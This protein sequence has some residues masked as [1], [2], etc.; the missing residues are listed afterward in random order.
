[1]AHR[2]QEWGVFIAAGVH[3]HRTGGAAA[4]CSILF[5]PDGDVLLRAATLPADDRPPVRPPIAP[6][7]LLGGGVALI[8]PTLAVPLERDATIAQFSGLVIVPVAPYA[9]SRKTAQSNLNWIQESYRGDA[10]W[11]VVPPAQ[12]KPAR[13]NGA[14]VTAFVA[15]PAVKRDESRAGFGVIR[16][17]GPHRCIVS[18]EL[19]A[20][21]ARV[22]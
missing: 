22:E 8:E 6:G 20:N 3:E 17:A 19:P 11:L 16:A 13:S 14:A 2:A 1:M 18:T 5:D 4:G 9:S 21:P 10:H 15:G 7:E 12:T